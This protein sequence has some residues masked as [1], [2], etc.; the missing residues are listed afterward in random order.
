MSDDELRRSNMQVV[1]DYIDAM[2]SWNFD[3]MGPLCGDDF[4]FE[5]LFPAPGL[6]SRI[7]GRE[8]MIEFQRQFAAQVR[9]ENM[10]IL[11][12][13]TLHSDPAEVIAICSSDMEFFDPS[14]HYSNEYIDRFTVR[15][16]QIRRFQ[17]NYDNVRLVRDFGGKVESPFEESSSA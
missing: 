10:R 9:T 8:P 11:H 12:I 2:N 14:R 13:D 6:P 5:M 16:G 1:Q 4:V 7:E 3:V 15:D 17:E